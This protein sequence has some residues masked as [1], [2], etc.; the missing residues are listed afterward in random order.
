MSRNEIHSF[1]NCK[2]CL[3]ELPDGESPESYARLSCGWTPRGMQLWCVRHNRNVVHINFLGQKVAYVRSDNV[4]ESEQQTESPSKE[5][6][7]PLN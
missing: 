4:E 7:G 2:E 1:F 6:M 5:E 3:D